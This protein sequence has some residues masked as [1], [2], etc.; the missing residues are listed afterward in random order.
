MTSRNRRLRNALGGVAF[1]LLFTA[2]TPDPGPPN[3]Q[4]VALDGNGQ[5][6]ALG[7]YGLSEPPDFNPVEGVGTARELCLSEGT[8]IRLV[9]DHSIEESADGWE[10]SHVVWSIE[11]NASWWQHEHGGDFGARVGVVDMVAVPDGS[12][13]VATGQLGV[14]TRSPDGQWTPDVAELRTLP[15]GLASLL[16]VLATLTM[17]AAG[18]AFGRPN[19]GTVPAKIA[20]FLL[21]PSVL[22]TA[23]LLSGAA[24]IGTQ[25]LAILPA[26]AAIPAAG[27]LLGAIVRAT[28]TPNY[29][30]GAL[31]RYVVSGVA[32][33]GVLTALYVL[34]SRNLSDWSVAII[35]SVLV[36]VVVHVGLPLA[37]K[38]LA[39]PAPAPTDFYS[40]D[41]PV[42]IL[43]AA[44]WSIVAGITTPFLLSV[45]SRGS[46]G[47]V[48]LLVPVLVVAWFVSRLEYDGFALLGGLDHDDESR[49]NISPESLAEI[50]DSPKS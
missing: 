37:L 40:I 21:L 17:I 9:D 49:P 6:V 25:V 24:G 2:C 15:L 13:A 16:V 50:L 28:R 43:A 44:G 19:Y 29:G 31:I 48:V 8:C 11:P 4:D 36:Y 33:V 38:H 46:W 10:T 7:D 47:I 20:F 41:S 5:V 1:A 32:L 35:G 45:S 39:V 42:T 34:W 26:L 12:V 23:R 30:H 18:L 27:L 22:V 3:I 14:I